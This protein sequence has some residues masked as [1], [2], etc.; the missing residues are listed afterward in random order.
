MKEYDDTSKTDDQSEDVPKGDTEPDGETNAAAAK[1]EVEWPNG[2]AKSSIDIFPEYDQPTD[3]Q[4]DR[5]NAENIIAMRSQQEILRQ[6][7]DEE[8]VRVIEEG[9]EKVPVSALDAPRLT[10]P[11]DAPPAHV[12]WPDGDAASPNI[13]P[14]MPLNDQNTRLDNDPHVEGAHDY[15]RG[16]IDVEPEALRHFLEGGSD[17]GQRSTLEDP[18][19]SGEKDV[20]A[21]ADRQNRG[22]LHDYV[23]SAAQ[24]DMARKEVDGWE[25]LS[26]KSHTSQVDRVTFKDGSEAY[27]KPA[28]GEDIAGRK[29]TAFVEGELWRNEI[30]VYE[31][32]DALGFNLAPVT[33]SYFRPADGVRGSIA[34]SV[35]DKGVFDLEN[36]APLD[37]QRGA[38]LHYVTGNTDGHL[39]NV[40][41]RDDSSPGIIDGGLCFPGANDYRKLD[42]LRSVF[43]PDVVGRP[44]DASIVDAARRVDQVRLAERLGQLGLSPEA[45]GGALGR[46]DEVV[47]GVITGAAYPG[48]LVDDD[49]NTVKKGRRS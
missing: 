37:L 39:G 35:G 26:M 28:E 20:P 31:V 10:K 33:T 45:I 7:H 1:Y 32:D 38:T 23:E 34:E 49:W 42:K 13:D 27:F 8:G 41:S 3:E 24:A 29:D 4:M 40:L 22:D 12:E 5:Q 11:T 6:Q 47:Q 36:A 2:D 16:L 19:K 9:I 15:L 18:S 46:L 21:V 14:T 44:L 43:F 25:P 17:G 30:A 48:R